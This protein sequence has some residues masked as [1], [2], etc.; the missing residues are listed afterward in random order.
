MAAVQAPP[1]APILAEGVYPPRFVDL[2]QQIL[3]DGV[4][5][6]NAWNEIISELAK[7]TKELNETGPPVRLA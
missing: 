7:V 6:V 3:P 2:K 4:N 5:V 1:A